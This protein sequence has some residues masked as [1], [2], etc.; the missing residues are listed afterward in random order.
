MVFMF[1]MVQVAAKIIILAKFK[2]VTI[3]VN[4]SFQNPFTYINSYLI[5]HWVLL[6]N[7]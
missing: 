2:L 7:Y 4:Q 3:K 1:I 6:V 5:K